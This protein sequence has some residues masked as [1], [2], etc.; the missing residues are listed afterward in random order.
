VTLWDIPEQRELR[1]WELAQNCDGLDARFLVELAGL[2]GDAGSAGPSLLSASA[3]GA[4]NV[5]S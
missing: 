5:F 4:V 1:T 3:N 2:N